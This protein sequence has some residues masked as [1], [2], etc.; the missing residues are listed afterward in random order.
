MNARWIVFLAA[1]TWVGH[2]QA[3]VIHFDCQYTASEEKIN[4]NKVSIDFDSETIQIDEKIFRGSNVVI[5]P[6][7]VIAKEIGGVPGLNSLR[8]ETYQIS[9]E[10]LSY[11]TAFRFKAGDFNENYQFEG[12]CEIVE[13]KQAF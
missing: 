12:K 6:T 8:T 4:R 2:S 3:R 11:T 5:S 13:K 10:D 7:A 1:L 9:R